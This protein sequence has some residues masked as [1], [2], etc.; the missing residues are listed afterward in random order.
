MSNLHTDDAQLTHLV[1]HYVGNSSREE[2]VRLSNKGT[3]VKQAAF[4]HLLR[5][6][7]MH[8]KPEESY[9]MALPDAEV[10]GTLFPI[11][12]QVLDREVEF[13][14]G[15][16]EL[17]QHLYEVATHPKV[18]SSPFHVVKFEG[19][20]LDGEELEAV[21][22]FKSET[23]EQFLQMIP[24]DEHYDIL[25]EE[26]TEIAGMDKGCL[27]F[28]TEEEEGYRVLV[29]NGDRSADSRYWNDDFL[30]LIARADDFHHTKEAM[31]I[32]SQFV[33]KEMNKEFQVDNTERIDLLNRS[34]NYFKE[35]E[36]FDKKEFAETVFQDE[37]VVESFDNF[38][39]GYR[40]EYQL[41][42][43]Q[44]FEISAPAVRKQGGVFKSILKLDKNF[45]V[46]IHGDKKM[47][48]RGTDDDGR[49]YYKLYFEEEK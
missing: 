5:Y 45:S 35:N 33:N 31:R 6:F 17:A 11:I 16:K 43:L 14:A 12:K 46:Y 1:T 28:K 21:G 39:K 26:G 23:T 37:Q 3:R 30:Q 25:I 29:H 44:N 27:V 41:E 42:P 48:E 2:G 18:K 47:I 22:L 7:F 20:I 10:P 40:Q 15:S 38:E 19:L 49:K 13:V 9:R 4:D 24:D 36:T 32:T 34:A 8:F